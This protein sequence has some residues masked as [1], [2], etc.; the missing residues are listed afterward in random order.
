[1]RFF[2]KK[3][4]FALLLIVFLLMLFMNSSYIG[5]KL[6]PIYFQEEIRQSASNNQVDPFLIA[7]II[8]VETNYKSHLESKKGAIGIMQLMPDTASWIVE[9]SDVGYY[10]VDDLKHANVSIQMGG[11]YIGWLLKHYNGNIYYTIA[12]YNAGQGNVNKWKQNGIWKGTP[13]DIDHIPFGETRHYIQRVLYYHNKYTDL[14]K[15]EWN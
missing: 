14:Y 8:R 13:E 9:T 10:T 7:A 2:R 3:R 6:Y 11:W 12:A 1:M 4:A 5:K 15:Q